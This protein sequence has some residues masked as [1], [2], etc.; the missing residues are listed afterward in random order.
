[1]PPGAGTSVGELPSSV[2]DQVFERYDTDKNG[3]LSESEIAKPRF[4]RPS[5]STNLSTELSRQSAPIS[6]ERFAEALRQSFANRP[7]TVVSPQFGGFGNR[8]STTTLESVLT[9]SYVILTP[10]READGSV[11]VKIVFDSNQLEGLSAPHTAAAEEGEGTET[12]AENRSPS[13]TTAS[14]S[15]MTA[16][17]AD[18]VVKLTP[19]KVRVIRTSVSDQE[20]SGRSVLVFVS[21][22]STK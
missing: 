12:P 22:G 18:S 5:G 15:D 11:A 6:K 7:P 19:G 9:G 1:M 13:A 17:R 3:E 8:P 16:A 21:L 20:H 4:D 10:E 2:I 14:Q